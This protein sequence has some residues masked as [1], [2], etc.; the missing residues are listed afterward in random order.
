[1]VQ[2]KD[3]VISENMKI[4]NN[5]HNLKKFNFKEKEINFFNYF[6]L[7]IFTQNYY[8]IKLTKFIFR[9]FKKIFYKKVSGFDEFFTPKI[10]S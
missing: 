5:S 9:K 1:M 3:Y 2:S 10:T 6:I 7:K 8:L 4:Y